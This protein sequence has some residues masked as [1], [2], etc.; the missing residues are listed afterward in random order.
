VR[1]LVY[2]SQAASGAFDRDLFQKTSVGIVGNVATGVP[3]RPEHI[4]AADS[5]RSSSLI[6][7]RRVVSGLE[8]PSDEKAAILSNRYGHNISRN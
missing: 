3:R 5:K 8:M 6:D 7:V 2:A 1:S 4:V